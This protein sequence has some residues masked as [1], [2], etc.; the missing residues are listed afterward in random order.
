MKRS[1]IKIM[2]SLGAIA[3]PLLYIM[4]PA[5]LMGVAGFLCAEFIT[6]LGGYG[7]VN[8]LGFEMAL[9]LK[10]ILVIISIIAVLRGVLHYAEQYS[11]HFIAFK[12][13]A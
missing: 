8:I 13:L 7:L 4:I 10:K 2:L 9:S 1:K 6:I 12:L 5:V 11:N 3:K